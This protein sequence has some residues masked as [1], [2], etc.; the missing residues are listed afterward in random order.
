MPKRKYLRPA[1]DRDAANA[2][3]KNR[4][5]RLRKILAHTSYQPSCPRELLT[6]L[7]ASV[8]RICTEENVN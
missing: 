8:A 4:D 3:L 1:R 2:Q 5:Y 7:L 6:G